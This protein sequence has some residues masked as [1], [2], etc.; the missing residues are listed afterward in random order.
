MPAAAA[1]RR[2]AAP[3]PSKAY[4]PIFEVESGKPRTLFTCFNRGLGAMQQN[5]PLTGQSQE[6]KV[7]RMAQIGRLNG[8]LTGPIYSRAPSNYA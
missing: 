4:L 2:A 5:A 7:V 1:P 6:F 3:R 8:T